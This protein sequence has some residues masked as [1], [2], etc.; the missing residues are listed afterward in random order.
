MG[1]LLVNVEETIPEL[2]KRWQRAREAAH[3]QVFASSL[4]ESDFLS[5][6]PQIEGEKFEEF[7][8]LVFLNSRNLGRSY[9]K[10]NSI[11]WE[12]DDFTKFAGHLGS[13]CLTGTWVKKDSAHVLSR[14]G[15]GEGLKFGRRYCQYWREAIDGLVLGIS[16][17]VGF[18]RNSS[19]SVEDGDC[20]DVFFDDES[21]PTGAIWSNA[22]KWG[23]L[24]E[25]LK[26]DLV[27]IEQKFIEMKIDL[28]F[29]GLSEKNLLYKLEP[30]ENLTC[31]SAGT[32][33]R[34]H[35]EKIVKEKF[36]LLTLKDASPVA[37]YG[38]RA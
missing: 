28:K 36:P 5:K 18:V 37:V 3:S 16:D 38:E 23:A 1:P 35:L 15:C 26:E 8:K 20:T 11:V 34:S 7:L 24:P 21:S 14:K 9:Q 32:I 19:I 22:N 13:P 31:G 10:A 4:Q 12:K 33:Y 29:L 2:T 6:L 30:E 17:E 25:S 27:N